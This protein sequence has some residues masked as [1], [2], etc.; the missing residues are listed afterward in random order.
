[1][2]CNACLFFSPSCVP[3]LATST[4]QCDTDGPRQ[5]GGIRM[6]MVPMR[7]QAAPG[8]VVS[9]ACAYFS[10][11]R[12][13]IDIQ[14]IG[15]KRIDGKLSSTAQVTSSLMLGPPVQD[16]LNR[17]PWGSRRS[18]SLIIDAS[19]RQVKCRVTNA[20]GLVLGELTALI[21]PQG[22]QKPMPKI[23]TK[24]IQPQN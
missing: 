19:H 9:F 7:T 17:Y 1:M 20:E 5:T 18:L 4:A 14:P 23:K 24:Q 15:Y 11:E 16:T 2:K 8:Q 21:Q 10:M 13:E 6:E 3:P 22:S 12:L